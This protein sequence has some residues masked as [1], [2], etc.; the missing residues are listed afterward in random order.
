MRRENRKKQRNMNIVYISG[1]VL[2]LAVIAFVIT[3]IAYGNKL[4]EQVGW[5]TVP[6]NGIQAATGSQVFVFFENG[7]VKYYDCAYEEYLIKK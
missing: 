3:F 6:H 7:N 2:G 5:C 4:N 1:I